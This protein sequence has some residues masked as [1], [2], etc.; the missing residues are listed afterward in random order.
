MIYTVVKEAKT[1]I[2]LFFFCDRACE[3]M[4]RM[5]SLHISLVSSR[6]QKHLLSDVPALCAQDNLLHC[7]E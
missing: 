5:Q 6:L 3:V 2:Q 7:D 4:S 1:M